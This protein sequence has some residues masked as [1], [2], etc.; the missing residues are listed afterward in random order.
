MDTFAKL[1]GIIL[2]KRLER[3]FK[4]EREQAG[5]QRGRGCLEHIVRFIGYDVLSFTDLAVACAPTHFRYAA[6][7]SV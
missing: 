2:C 6:I 3:W 1:F 7:L 5:A 4:P